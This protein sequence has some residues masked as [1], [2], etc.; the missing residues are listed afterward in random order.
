MATHITD[1]E[2][3][4]W[5]AADQLRA[6]S[7]LSAQEYSVPV[8][9][10]IF[11]RY[12][13]Y[14]FSRAAADVETV[15]ATSLRRRK[16]SKLDYQA[17]GVMYVPDDARFQTLVNLPE[18]EDI[19]RAVNDAMKA[20]ERENPTLKDVLP[21]TYNRLRNSTLATLLKRLNFPDMEIDDDVFGRIYEY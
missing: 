2:K 7:N 10:L 6:N 9:G 8:L 21:K 5:G 16:I 17:M 3:L 11:L 14:K 1:L 19:G 12:A 20:I 4:L 13:D 15:R 18:G